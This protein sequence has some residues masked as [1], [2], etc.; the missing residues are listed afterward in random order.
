MPILRKILDRVQKAYGK[1]D[2]PPATDPFELILYENIAYLAPDDRREAAFRAL[3]E[4]AGSTPAEILRASPDALHRAAKLGGILAEHRVKKL[5]RAAQIAQEKFAGRV[6]NEKR[7]LKLFP[8]IGDP[9]AERILLFT[10]TQPV[11]ALDSNG[12]RVLVR[13]G[14]GH[15]QTSY[16]ATYRSAQQAAA[17]EIER[18]CGKLIRAHQLLRRHGQ[19]TC[20]NTAPR[21]VECVVSDLCR[22]YRDHECS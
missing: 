14:Y 3:R 9:R 22:Y 16:A 4:Q 20:K 21:C 15:G 2:G 8:S 12:L 18:D 13:L 11:L 10:K 1:P 5:L 7:A 6:P 19:K 17:A